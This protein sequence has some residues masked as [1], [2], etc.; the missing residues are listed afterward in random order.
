MVDSNTYAAGPAMGGRQL[1]VG[2]RHDRVEILDEAAAPVVVLP[3]VFGQHS[4][5]VFDPGLLLPLLVRKPGSWG[6]SPVRDTAPAPVRDWLDHART[7]E[8][9]Q[10]LAAINQAVKPAGLGNALA[11]AEI[12]IGR[13]EPVEP[14]AV[15]MLARRLAAGAEPATGIADLAVYDGLAGIKTKASA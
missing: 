9:R 5:T 8:R 4:A 6:N 11:A 10:M 7:A 12:V 2:L 1:T 13:G 3:R 15:G 14:A